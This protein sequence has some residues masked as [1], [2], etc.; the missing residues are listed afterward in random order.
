MD[1]D[2]RTHTKNTQSRKGKVVRCVCGGGGGLGDW[3]DDS[4]NLFAAELKITPAPMVG[5]GAGHGS[6]HLES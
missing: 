1:S 4:V 3:R 2:G 5:G 6:T